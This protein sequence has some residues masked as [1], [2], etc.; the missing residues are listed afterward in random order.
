MGTDK[1]RAG[2]DRLAHRRAFENYL[3]RGRATERDAVALSETANGEQRSRDRS[4]PRLSKKALGGERP[5]NHYI[6]RTARDERV[7][8][9]HTVNEGRIFAWSDPPRT[10]HPGHEPNC[11]CWAEP[12][13]G[14]PA[15]SG[16]GPR[17]RSVRTPATG[18]EPWTW[19]ETFTRPDGS[20]A[21]SLVLGGDGTR[22]HSTFSGRRVT[23]EVV[24]AGGQKV[25]LDT[26]DGVQSAYVGND[27]TPVLQSAWTGNGP[28]VSVPRTRVAQLLIGPNTLRPTDVDLFAPIPAQTVPREGAVGGVLALGLLALYNMQRAEPAVFGAGSADTSV[29]AFKVWKDDT[30]KGTIAASVEA[31]TAV[32]V[33]QH[34]KRLPEVQAWT[35]EA[36]TAL[37]PQR[38]VLGPQVWGTAVHTR[39]K[40]TVTTLREELPLA[41]ADINAELSLAP[42]EDPERVRYGQPGTT[43]LDIIE[44]VSSELVCVYDIKTGRAGLSSTRVQTIAERVAAAQPGASF[45]IMEVRPFE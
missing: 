19:I 5:T 44:K 45:Y 8:S 41:Y 43:R 4:R 39:I 17:R 25:T 38:S 27:R 32:Q 42:P 21:E 12:Y 34:C 22:F 26:V 29:I 10:G 30:R 24:L 7:R 28:V 23:H 6:W 14:D 37:A 33:S 13:Y 40:D 1:R 11:R 15:L 9:S 18:Q 20:L 35:N 3:R 31:L 16:N 36:A 2:L